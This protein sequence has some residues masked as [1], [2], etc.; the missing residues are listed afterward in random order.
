MGNFG[1]TEILLIFFVILIFFGGKKIP[2]IAKGLG[3]GIKNFKKS[4][5]NED[6]D[7]KIEKD[8]KDDIDTPK[9]DK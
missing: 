1:L 4:V 7:D 8:E 5:S 9:I 3:E 2:E 6:S